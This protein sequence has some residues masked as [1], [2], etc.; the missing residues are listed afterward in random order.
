MTTFVGVVFLLGGAAMIIFARRIARSRLTAYFSQREI[1]A[2]AQPGHGRV[3]LAI[4]GV[5]VA[6]AVLGLGA[7]YVGV[8]LMF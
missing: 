5:A 4:A 1:A 3:R 7:I 8:R 6:N 2:S